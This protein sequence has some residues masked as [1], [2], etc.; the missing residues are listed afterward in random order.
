LLLSV[1]ANTGL[2]SMIDDARSA[3]AIAIATI[4]DIVELF[5]IFVRIF[6]YFKVPSQQPTPINQN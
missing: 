3:V 2:A 1:V 4:V 5:I 6:I